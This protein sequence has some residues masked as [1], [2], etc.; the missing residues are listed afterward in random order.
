MKYKVNHKILGYDGKPFH[1]NEIKLDKVL[2]DG[3]RKE[4]E[5]G[6]I[7]QPSQVLDILKAEV[8]RDPLTIKVVVSHALNSIGKNENGGNEVLSAA[9]RHKCYEITTKLFNAKEPDFTEDQVRFIIDRV[10][11]IWLAPIII[12]R[13]NEFFRGTK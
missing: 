3:F 13:V 1:D 4:I 2:I 8:E 6:S 12:G 5:R 9:D 7:T 11:K 10:E